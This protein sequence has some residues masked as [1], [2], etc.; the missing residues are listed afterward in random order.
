MPKGQE[1]LHL[2][3]AGSPRSLA[4]KPAACAGCALPSGCGGG[5]G[6]G[7]LLLLGLSL[8]KPWAF[9]MH[10]S[11]PWRCQDADLR[12]ATDRGI[13]NNRHMADMPGGLCIGK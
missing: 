10:R 4:D 6:K 8:C 3:A 1:A 7:G 2:R 13:V 12:E 5:S 11:G 9:V